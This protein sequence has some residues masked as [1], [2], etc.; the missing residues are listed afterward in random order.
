MKTLIL[1]EMTTVLDDEGKLIF[2][3]R[4][5]FH[6]EI[7]TAL[8]LHTEPLPSERLI[9]MLCREADRDLAGT[10]TQLTSLVHQTRA[11]ISPGR[12]VNE[13]G[14]GYRL[15]RFPEEDVIDVDDFQDL[16]AKGLEAHA[17]AS[18]Y[19]DLARAAE[20]LL[21]AVMLWRHKPGEPLLPDLPDTPSMADERERLCGLRRKA[22]QTYVEIQLSRGR[23]SPD[24]GAW[25]RRFL[26]DDP[27]DEFLYAL[28]MLNEF[29]IG[30][31]AAA[32]QA[33]QDAADALHR[34]VESPPG[35]TLTRLRDRIV[36]GASDWPQ[37]PRLALS[38]PD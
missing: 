9:R 38:L 5:V 2:N 13:A 31:A 29:R 1:G 18:T 26:A 30:R 23:Q 8:A 10:I 25:I 28:L 24:L 15:A 36:S 12:L 37:N 33:Y 17:K 34:T 21:Q 35:R 14:K 19:G 20:S 16:V 22:V 4:Q 32:L 27:A 7:M 11:A 6:R 3:R